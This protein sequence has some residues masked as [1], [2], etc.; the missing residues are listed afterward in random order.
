MQERQKTQQ[1]GCS[2][3]AT[4]GRDDDDR[5]IYTSE[6]AAMTQLNVTVRFPDSTVERLSLSEA[7]ELG[8]KID[9]RGVRWRV[10]GMRLPWGLDQHRDVLYDLDVEPAPPTS[11]SK[12]S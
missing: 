3:D 6:G 4:F 11:T 5:V 1:I 9:A 10:T 2:T 7:P 8:S 12:G